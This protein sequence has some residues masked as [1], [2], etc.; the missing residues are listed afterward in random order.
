VQN[1]DISLE[2]G[3][4][5][6][7]PRIDSDGVTPEDACDFDTVAGFAYVDELF[8]STQRDRVRGLAIWDVVGCF[9][10]LND[11]LVCEFAAVVNDLHR[12]LG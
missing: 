5:R 11:L 8:V 12:I 3:L 2:Q 4:D 7:L 6:P 10:E 1:I 9:L